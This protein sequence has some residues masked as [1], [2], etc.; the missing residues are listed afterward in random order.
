MHPG[1]RGEQRGLDS[2][3]A[4]GAVCVGKVW[5]I[6]L[7]SGEGMNRSI[8]PLYGFDNRARNL[9]DDATEMILG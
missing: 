8:S 4:K 5:S 1:A 7:D 9:E 3:C 6:K 2:K